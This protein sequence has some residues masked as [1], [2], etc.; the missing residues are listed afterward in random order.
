MHVFYIVII[1]VLLLTNV[2]M[3][4]GK[5]GR[6]NATADIDKPLPITTT[7]DAHINLNTATADELMTIDGIG[8]VTAQKIL[9]R[10]KEL[11]QFRQVEDLLS[12][13]GF[14][15]GKLEDF[16]EYFYVE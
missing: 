1:A 10:R 15:E 5:E 2:A 14:G 9:L 13:D 8:P 3:Y 4:L 16:K 11:G 12:V 6:F 7:E